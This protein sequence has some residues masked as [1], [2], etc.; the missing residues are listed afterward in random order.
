MLGLSLTVS[1]CGPAE[2][3]KPKGSGHPIARKSMSS[4]DVKKTSSTGGGKA[5]IM[6]TINGDSNVPFY[7]E[8]ASQ[9]LTADDCPIMAFSVAEDPIASDGRSTASGSPCLLELFPIDRPPEN[10]KFVRISRIIA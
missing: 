4:G 6:S 5:C 8:F 3:E 10:K 2:N 1:G 9:G 7:K